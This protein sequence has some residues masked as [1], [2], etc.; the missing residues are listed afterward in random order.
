MTK[1]PRLES[2]L[3][4]FGVRMLCLSQA[5]CALPVYRLAMAEAGGSAT[6]Q[7][8]Y[9]AGPADCVDLVSELL[10]EAMRRGE[11]RAPDPHLAAS[12]LIALVTSETRSRLFQQTPPPLALRQIR[13]MARRAVETF[14]T[15]LAARRPD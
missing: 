6:G 15:G 5:E 2:V 4:R 10:S 1:T 3:I 9:E 12:Q 11:L 7:L 14:L 13:S 8:F